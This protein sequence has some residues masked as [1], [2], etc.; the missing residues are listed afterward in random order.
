MSDITLLI[1]LVQNQ[2][3][4]EINKLKA[5]PWNSHRDAYCD[6]ATKT[7]DEILSLLNAMR[8]LEEYK[9]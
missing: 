7:C 5:G 9:K 2:K 4:D 6:G 3:D 1:S 8:I